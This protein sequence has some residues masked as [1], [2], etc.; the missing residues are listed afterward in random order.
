[1]DALGLAAEDATDVISTTNVQTNVHYSIMVDVEQTTKKITYF[2]QR[3][4]VTVYACNG[5]KF[6]ILQVNKNQG[7]LHLY[8]AD[9]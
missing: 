4:S 5:N 1:M 9:V 7:Y 2:E 8:C 3:P 6:L